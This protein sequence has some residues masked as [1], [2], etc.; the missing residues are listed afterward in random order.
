MAPKERKRKAP[1]KKENKPEEEVMCEK[2]HNQISFLDP[3]EKITELKDI[4]QW[5]R[6]S[7]INKAVTFSTTVYKSLIKAFWNSA[8]VVQIDGTEVIQGQVNDLNVVVSP[9]ILSTVLEL[10]DNPDAPFSIPIMCTRGFLLRMKCIGEIFSS[11]INKGD[12]PLRYKFILHILIQCISNR[13]GGYDMVGNDLVGLMVA[14]VLNK[15][16]S[17]SKYIFTNM[18]ENKTRTGSRITGN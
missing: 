6:E 7:R 11:Q 4:T 13:R 18:K 2:R 9:E 14:L 16:F 3:E 12:L 1:T 8:S 5:I 15:P 10:Q 17:I